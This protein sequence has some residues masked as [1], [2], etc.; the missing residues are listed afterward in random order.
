MAGGGGQPCSVYLLA[1][2]A[3][4]GGFLFGYDTGVISGAMAVILEEE[5]GLL[6]G[7]GRAERDLW[8][9]AIVASTIATAAVF[10]LLSGPPSQLLGRKPTILAASVVFAAGSVVM[11]V[12]GDKETLLGG[13]VVVGAAIGLASSVVPVYIS[14]AAPAHL[15][16]SLTVSYNTLVVAGQFVATLVCGA[17]SSVSGGWRW[18]LGLAGLPAII[19]LVGFVFMPESPRWLVS[20]GRGDEARDI[21]ATIRP[22]GHDV[23]AEVADISAAV[24]K[25]RAGGGGGGGAGATLAR[26]WRHRPTRRALALGCSLQLFQQISG[27]N[28]IMYYSATVVQMAGV[29]SAS[30]A[31]WITAGINAL[32]LLACGIGVAGV[33]RLGRRRLLLAS[34]AGVVASLL[35]IGVMF[36]RADSTTP[37][38]NTTISSCP[39]SQDAHNCLQCLAEECGFC[40]DKVSGQ[41]GCLLTNSSQCGG[42]GEWFE[43]FCPTSPA[44]SWTIIVGLAAYLVSFAAGIAPIPWTVNAEIYPLWGRAVCTSLA[45]ATNWSCNLLIA[46][47]FLFLTSWLTRAGAFLLYCGLALLG[48]IIFFLFLPE[49]SGRS[50]E[51]MEQLFSGKLIVVN[52]NK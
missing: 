34:L 28:T 11:G 47:T 22:A 32:Y 16:G 40:Y 50:L 45:T 18:M 43:E 4:V 3:A 5:G 12:A 51:E 37:E 39:G 29:G 17:F 52:K 35:L 9:Q 38:V 2:L 41:G 20:R 48:W 23:A 30:S 24:E 6:A 8:H 1:A 33:E 27:I 46:M 26:V 44:T 21:L 13:R 19:Q 7:L 42:A 14:E 10:A 36:Q 49:T 31:I 15:R 25:D